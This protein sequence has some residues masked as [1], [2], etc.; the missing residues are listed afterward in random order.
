VNFDDR[1]RLGHD[2]GLPLPVNGKS[3]LARLVTQGGRKASSSDCRLSVVLL[4]DYRSGRDR[5][6]PRPMMERPGMAQTQSEK[7]LPQL[8]KPDPPRRNA[9]Q[10]GSK[11][12][13]NAN[14]DSDPIAMLHADHRRVEQLFG[15][16]EKASSAKQKSQLAKQIC[17]ELTI[18][19]LID[20]EIF[21]PACHP[22]GCGWQAVNLPA[23][24]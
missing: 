13:Q 17:T 4:R 10:R 9:T 5:V 11:N 12:E 6:C 21:Y 24:S 15:S 1:G 3:S 18:H 19:T 14:S 20:E 16:F 2:P 22:N 8:S 23:T 7:P